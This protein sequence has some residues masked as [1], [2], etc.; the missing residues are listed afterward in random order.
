MK[1]T[2]RLLVSYKARKI[3]VQGKTNNFTKKSQLQG[4][5]YI[6]EGNNTY[7]GSNN[8][9]WKEARFSVVSRK[10]CHFPTIDTLVVRWSVLTCKKTKIENVTQHTH[11]HTP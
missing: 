6:E 2:V 3:A 10:H 1:M 4:S 8:A 7:L 5:S 11:T 9:N